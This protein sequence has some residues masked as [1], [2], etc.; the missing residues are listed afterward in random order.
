MRACWLILQFSPMVG[1][2]EVPLK[3]ILAVYSGNRRSPG[4][5][6]FCNL[7]LGV[8][9]IGSTAAGARLT[10][11]ANGSLPSVATSK[12]G[13]HRLY[14][15]PPLDTWPKTRPAS[16]DSSLGSR[17]PRPPARLAA[18]A[19]KSSNTRAASGSSWLTNTST[20]RITWRSGCC[21]TP[22]SFERPAV[23]PTALTGAGSPSASSLSLQVCASRAATVQPSTRSPRPTSPKS[24]G[25]L[26]LRSCRRWPRPAER[27]P[28]IEDPSGHQEQLCRMQ[29]PNDTA[30]S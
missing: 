30:R 15:R 13:T 26:T 29:K 5:G 3:T 18:S 23:A 19:R 4:V 27:L 6:P 9:A 24:V 12:T 22:S 14:R 8:P 17:R 20:Q 10:R 28:S 21:D 25:P 1:R 11:V 16:G 2:E 7:R